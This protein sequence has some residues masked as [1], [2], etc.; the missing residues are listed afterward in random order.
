MESADRA[1]DGA[2]AHPPTGTPR[3]TSFHCHACGYNLTGVAIGAAC[4]ECGAAVERSLAGGIL[5]TSG[6]AIASMVLGICSIVT[7]FCYG[8]PG[9]VCSILAIV[10]W[11]KAKVEIAAGTVSSGSASM[12]TAGLIT[13]ICG[14]LLSLLMIAYFVVI[15]ILAVSGNLP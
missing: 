6:K 4:P 2:D 14:G 10:F 3:T 11:R 9:I 8:L 12:A 7:C 1:T 15:I 5:P 13:G